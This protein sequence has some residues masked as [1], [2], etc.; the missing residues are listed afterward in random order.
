MAGNIDKKG[1][2]QALDDLC[3]WGGVTRTDSKLNMYYNS[4]GTG[5]LL[6]VFDDYFTLSTDGSIVYYFYDSLYQVALYCT[7]GMQAVTLQVTPKRELTG[8]LLFNNSHHLAT[9]DKG[10]GQYDGFVLNNK[11]K[12]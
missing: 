11:G 5:Y 6:S 1:M 2:V 12:E 10:N 3:R 9:L 4:R 8:G 7:W